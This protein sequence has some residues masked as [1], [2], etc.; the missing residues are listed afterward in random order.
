H[1]YG[2]TILQTVGG[3]D[4]RTVWTGYAR[5]VRLV[6]QH[7]RPIAIR[8]LTYRYERR[9]V[10]VHAEDR[11]GDDQTPPRRTMRQELFERRH[12]RMWV[13]A[14][15]R[16]RQAA[17]VDEAGMVELITKDHV[18]LPGQSCDRADVRM[19]PGSEQQRRLGM[20][21]RRQ[22]FLQLAVQ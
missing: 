3:Y 15:P 11:V 20:L 10:A 9:D 18:T 19:V 6:D 2:D 16:P 21:E 8:Q 13:H 22:L 17:P 14:H 1:L 12:V 5:G 4:A 7:H